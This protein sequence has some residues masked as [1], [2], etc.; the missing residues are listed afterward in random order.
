MFHK[1]SLEN[2]TRESLLTHCIMVCVYKIVD[3][4]G[5]LWDQQK[6]H[7]EMDSFSPFLVCTTFN[8][9]KIIQY[10]IL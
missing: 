6:A 9:C 5:L 10:E 1:K 3:A 8:L 2:A 4:L 7:L